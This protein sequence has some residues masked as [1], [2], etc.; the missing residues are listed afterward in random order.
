L[1]NLLIAEQRSKEI[2][3]RKVHGAGVWHIIVLLSKDYAKLMLIAIILAIP[4][5]YYYAQQWLDNFE[6]RM[7]LSPLIFILGGLIALAI[8]SLTVSFKSYQA[9]TVNP[10]IDT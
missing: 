4:F 2:G 1:H 8:G 9:A 6:F 3:V 7:T 5:A 10:I